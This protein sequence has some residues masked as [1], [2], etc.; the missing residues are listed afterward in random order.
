MSAAIQSLSQI[1]DYDYDYD[2][3]HFLCFNRMKRKLTISLFS[4]SSVIESNGFEN[5]IKRLFKVSIFMHTVFVFRTTQPWNRHCHGRN[6]SA[7][8]LAQRHNNYVV[9]CECPK[10]YSELEGLFNHV[11]KR[12][13]TTITSIKSHLFNYS[14]KKLLNQQ[15]KEQITSDK[16][17]H[18]LSVDLSFTTCKWIMNFLATIQK[19]YCD[20]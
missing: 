14:Q 2:W 7:S 8:T 16:I 12:V 10:E 6:S 17:E 5:L 13:A 11:R 20:L 18:E 4:V 9:A 15:K 3:I 19:A 1:N